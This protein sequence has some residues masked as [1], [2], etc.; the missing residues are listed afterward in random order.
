M[1]QR[2]RLPTGQIR[3]LAVLAGFMVDMLIS[4]I[5][6]AVTQGIDPQA[7]QGRWFGSPTAILVG[8]LLV[9]STVVGG[10]LAGLIAGDERFLHGF[11]VGGVGILL[12]LIQ[13][14]F[15]TS[16]TIDQIVLQLAATGLAGCAGY[17]SRWTPIGLRK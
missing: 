5:I 8:I 6:L 9:L 16:A 2:E 15:G 14:I 7:T 4:S 12:L 17:T 3:W 11:L 13:P 1:R 10:W